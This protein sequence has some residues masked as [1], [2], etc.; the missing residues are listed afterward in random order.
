[1][2]HWQKKT[3]LCFVDETKINYCNDWSKLPN[4][5]KVNLILDSGLESTSQTPFGMN[6]VLKIRKFVQSW[7]SIYI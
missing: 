7:K 5:A 2:D 6:F 1:M 3:P 4:R